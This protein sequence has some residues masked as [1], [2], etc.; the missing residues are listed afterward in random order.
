[1]RPYDPD[2]KVAIA[3]IL[4]KREQ[5]DD[6]KPYLLEAAKYDSAKALD[7]AYKLTAMILAIEG[8]ETSAL[9]MAYMPIMIVDP[10]SSDNWLFHALMASR[11]GWLEEAE[12]SKNQAVKLGVSGGYSYL[13]LAEIELRLGNN[14]VARQYAQRAI[15]S[16]INLEGIIKSD[17]LLSPLLR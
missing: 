16:D 14:E 12:K 15:E 2:V 5:Y 13:Y 17:E 7:E 8:N 9:V 11:F 3:R 1:V 10:T 6:A 4:F